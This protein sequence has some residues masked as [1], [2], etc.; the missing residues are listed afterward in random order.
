[1]EI[2]LPEDP[3]IP[4][5]GIYSKESS[6][7]YALTSKWILAKKKK[8]GKNTKYSRYSPYNSKSSIN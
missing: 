6:P 1:M 5:L 7:W 8:K 3:V 2:D 4:V